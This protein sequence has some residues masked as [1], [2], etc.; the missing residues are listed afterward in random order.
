MNHVSRP[1]TKRNRAPIACNSCRRTKSKVSLLSALAVHKASLLTF[2]AFLHAS[3]MV[4]VQLAT[5]AS[6]L[7]PS[8]DT[9]SP[10]R[11]NG[12]SAIRREGSLPL[13]R[14]HPWMVHAETGIG[15][16]RIS[17]ARSMIWNR[18]WPP[19]VVLMVPAH[20]QLSPQKR[21]SSKAHQAEQMRR[22]MTAGRRG[23]SLPLM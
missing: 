11:T 10:S 19:L 2:A 3:A 22:E 7:A 17:R 23:P 12:W 6:D 18:S 16:S 4:A 14:A 8:A 5:V 20:L 15:P 13:G 1:L 21:R 9:P